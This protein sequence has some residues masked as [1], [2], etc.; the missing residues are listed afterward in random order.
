MV[1]RKRNRRLNFFVKE[2][3][4][5]TIE[6]NMKKMGTNN[7]SAYARKKLIDGYIIRRDFR[8]IK[9]LTEEISNIAISVNE[10]AKRVNETRNIYEQDILD[11]KGYI[12]KVKS[13]VS[14]SLVKMN[15][16]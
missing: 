7:F 16:K 5:A 10:I 8:E 3:E 12:K 14:E 13:A 2:E 15:N 4:K 1:N 11:L 6:K 9:P